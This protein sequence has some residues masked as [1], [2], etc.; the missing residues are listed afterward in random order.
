MTVKKYTFVVPYTL[1]DAVD[2]EEMA[3]FDSFE[4]MCQIPYVKLHIEWGE[5][6]P[7]R[8]QFLDFSWREN[9]CE[10]KDLFARFHKHEER[11]PGL[12]PIVLVGS[13]YHNY[14]SL[15]PYGT[16]K[17]DYSQAID[18]IEVLMLE[19]KRRKDGKYFFIK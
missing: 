4:E 19:E 11:S 14:E 17:K 10:Q 2:C 7:D 12:C 6:R 5:G 13:I 3:H 1:S 9:D 18:D 16:P 8:L 15:L